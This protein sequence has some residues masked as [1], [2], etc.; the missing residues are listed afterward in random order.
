MLYIMTE[1]ELRD[2]IFDC[3]NDVMFT[4]NGK[5]SGITVE[6]HNSAPTYQVWHGSEIREYDNVDD[7]MS[8][9]FYSGKSINELLGDIEFR[10][11]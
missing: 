3:C 4:Y 6:V 1:Q 7:V 11:T 10:F 2:I 9:K 5:M 8:D